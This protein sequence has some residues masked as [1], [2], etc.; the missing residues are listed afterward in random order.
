MSSATTL[1]YGEHVERVRAF[2]DTEACGTHYV[3]HFASDREFF[4]KYREFRY[5]TEWHIPEFAAFSAAAGKHVLEIGCGNGT[6]GVM[7]ALNGASYTG[8][9]LTA[10]AVDATRRHF[11]VEGLRGVFRQENCAVTCQLKRVLT[12]SSLHS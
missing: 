3:T 12:S 9:D 11:A 7:F 2:W 1:P 10:E 5:R 4:S 6:D 8:V